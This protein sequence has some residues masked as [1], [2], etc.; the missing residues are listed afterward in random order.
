MKKEMMLVRLENEAV[1]S[2]LSL[3]WSMDNHMKNSKKS[4]IYQV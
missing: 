3:K 1:I 2:E 4:S